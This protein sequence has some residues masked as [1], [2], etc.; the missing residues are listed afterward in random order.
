MSGAVVLAARAAF[1]SGAGLV[2][3]I[4]PDSISKIIHTL[5]IE[6]IVKGVKTNQKFGTFKENSL[7]STYNL[8]KNSDVMLIGP[9]MGQNQSTKKL[10]LKL[11]KNNLVKKNKNIKV[12]LDADAICLI[13][14]KYIKNQ[15]LS[16]YPFILTPH[17]GEMARLLK[18]NTSNIKNNRIEIASKTSKELNSIIILKGA[19]T[20]IS[21]PKKEIY[22][23]TTGNSGMATAGSGDVL[24]GILSGLLGQGLDC[25]NAAKL[26]V[27]IHG[28]AGDYSKKGKGTLGLIASDIVENIPK[29]ILSLKR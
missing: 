22:I 15:K 24:S 8:I 11:L 18:T 26:A 23:N 4:C 1:R 17:A 27:Y 7:D 3:V 10:L 19:N 6:S 5:T 25:F 20:V 28:L 14:K 9:G 29:A 13:D 2:Y 16:K 21:N 12:I